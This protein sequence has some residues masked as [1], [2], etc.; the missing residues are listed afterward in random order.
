MGVE[1]WDR[2]GCGRVNHGWVWGGAVIGVEE[3]GKN[4]CVGMGQARVWRGR[5]GVKRGWV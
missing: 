5:T 3:L 4:W 2:D 1:G